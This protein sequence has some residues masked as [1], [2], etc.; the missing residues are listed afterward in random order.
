[1]VKQITGTVT[2]D[3][4]K[5]LPSVTVSVKGSQIATASDSHWSFFPL[6]LHPIQ[7]WYS[8]LLVLQNR[9]VSLNGRTSLTVVLISTDKNLS[10]VIVTTLGVKKESEN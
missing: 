4:G 7:N 1:M 8:P 5:R 6:L 3:N 9:K 10:E 2:D